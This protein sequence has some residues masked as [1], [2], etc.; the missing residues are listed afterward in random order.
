MLS[1]ILLSL[2]PCNIFYKNNNNTGTS[3]ITQD[4]IYANST[5]RK[6]FYKTRNKNFRDIN[7]ILLL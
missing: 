6:L 7:E 1:S 4:A 2:S 5:S 3:Q